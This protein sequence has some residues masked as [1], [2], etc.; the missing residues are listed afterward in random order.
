MTRRIFLGALLAVL[1]M[2]APAAPILR[3]P[4]EPWRLPETRI[5][6][7]SDYGVLTDANGVIQ[8]TNLGS[9]PD[10]VQ[11]INSFKPSLVSSVFP[12]GKD[13][14]QGDDIE[15]QLDMGSVQT[16]TGDWTVAWVVD[17][18][19]TFEG[20]AL[21]AEAG[22]DQFFVSGAFNE[23]AVRT[24]GNPTRAATAAKVH[25]NNPH[26]YVVC[27][28]QAT[29]NKISTQDG[30]D[31]SPGPD[32]SDNFQM[33]YLLAYNAS[34]A[35]AGS[36]FPVGVIAVWDTDLCEDGFNLQLERWLADWSGI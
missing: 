36:G 14:I 2:A 10:P 20:G 12:S 32:D 25:D 21:L 22:G 19:L 5:F 8:W 26:Y 11:T 31:V 15:Q 30:I 1:L 16:T 7:R 28:D 17:D 13:A 23:W 6:V 27:S 29:G 24:Q 35:G 33:Q 4:F 18:E 9:W 34:G 3:I